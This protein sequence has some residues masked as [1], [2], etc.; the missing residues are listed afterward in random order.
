MTVQKLTD[1]VRILNIENFS[2]YYLSK[3]FAPLTFQSKPMRTAL[4]FLFLLFI[5][6]SFETVGYNQTIIKGDQNRIPKN[7]LDIKPQGP[8]P[9]E[10]GCYNV[11]RYRVPIPK[12]S[13][14]ST[15]IKS[16]PPKPTHTLEAKWN[17]ILCSE[18]ITDSLY[19][20]IFAALSGNGYTPKDNYDYQKY[21]STYQADINAKAIS[22]LRQYQVDNNLPYKDI[23]LKTLEN[24][25]INLDKLDEAAQKF[26]IQAP[27]KKELLKYAVKFD[28]DTIDEDGLIGPADGK[29]SI[30]YNY[31]V[32]YTDSD[33]EAMTDLLKG[34]DPTFSLIDIPEKAIHS[35]CGDNPC[36]MAT[37]ETHQENYLD[38][39]LALTELKEVSQIFERV[40]R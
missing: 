16:N 29:R 26:K 3:A 24:L 27:T 21:I 2:Y 1:G 4:K 34:I 5:I 9:D 8:K 22:C 19:T 13:T 17:E 14:A 7:Y 18:L 39:L 10:G 35:V 6:L 30:S 32:I 25:D 11:H 15:W 12:D 33:K 20:I 23:S 28:L 36:F 38:V 37:G 40:Y 31:L